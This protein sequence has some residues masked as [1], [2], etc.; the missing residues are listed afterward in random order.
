MTDHAGTR[1]R[2]ESHSSRVRFVTL[3]QQL[4]VLAV[5]AT[6]LTPAARTISLDVRPVGPDASGAAEGDAVQAGDTAS[7]PSD[8]VEAKVRKVA[9]TAQRGVSA[10]SHQGGVVQQTP[11]GQRIT[12]GPLQAHGYAAVGLTWDRG[13]DIDDS[14]IAF[15]V[16]SL[17]D[18]AWSRWEEVPYHSEHQPDVNSGDEESGRPG[19]EPVV[20]GEVSR[21]QVR[22]TATG[23][24]PAGL[25]VSVID[26]GE[27]EESDTQSPSLSTE[28]S[29]VEESDEEAEGDEL[30]LTA[31]N[32]NKPRIFSRRQWGANEE[33]RDRGSLSYY[34]VHAGYVH[35]T[36]TSNDYSRDQ[37][38]N[39]IRSIYSYHTR[40][41]GWSDIGYNFLVDRFGRIWEGRFGGVA[42]PVVGAHTLG[43]NDYA[44]GASAIGNFETTR[45][46]DQMVNAFARLFGWKLS[47][48][49]VGPLKSGAYRHGGRVY[50]AV[51]GHRDAGSTACPG[52]Y[53]YARLGEIRQKAKRYQDG[54]G[55]R[56]LESH[57]VGGPAPDLIMRRKSDGRGFVLPLTKRPNGTYGTGRFVDTG[58]DLSR[59]RDVIKGG[60]WDLD[61][62]GDIIVRNRGDD[63]LLLYRGRGNNT[64][65]DAVVIQRNF[66]SV[67]RLVA[68][69]D[70]DGDGRPDLIGQPRDVSA[71]MLYPGRGL[72]GVA[73]RQRMTHRITMGP[74]GVGRWDPDGAPDVLVRT[75]SDLYVHQGNGPGG[76]VSRR[77]MGIDVGKYN[78][79]VGVHNLG[80]GEH[81]DIVAR[82]RYTNKL[83]FLPARYQGAGTFQGK[84]IPLGQ[85]LGGFDHIS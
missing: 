68:V 5:V 27:S 10:R 70:Y 19:T 45:P 2:T 34:E 29:A 76:Y 67:S 63:R 23:E 40:S 82:N 8:D 18:G 16:R 11:A 48:H 75:R 12:S 31:A 55:G 13:V 78:A 7:V 64:F 9:L 30:A 43:H 62:H 74:I 17:E 85:R 65:A 28:Q 61:G 47:L 14:D 3:C 36:V 77:K 54:F 37:V 71:T 83:Y 26:P 38:D 80:E 41:R 22:A 50:P 59:A 4:L 66:K 25:D 52:S 1:S 73:Y 69:G 24:V 60:D 53:L 6:L 51:N 42:R 79:F 20:V 21:V 49:G 58:I 44:F 56:Q 33:W 35:H 57:L 84:V 46:S 32:T 39:I 81:V 15:E 72:Q